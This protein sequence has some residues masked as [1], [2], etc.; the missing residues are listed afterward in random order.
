MYNAKL[1]IRKQDIS[2]P[3]PDYMIPVDFYQI[4]KHII[5]FTSDNITSKFDFFKRK[6][7]CTIQTDGMKTL[8]E[9]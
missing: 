8:D 5:N 1:L 3:I 6:N 9:Y 2:P 7:G 4:N